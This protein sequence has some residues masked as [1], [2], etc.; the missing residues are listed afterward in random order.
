[1]G[2]L[3]AFLWLVHLFLLLGV[4]SSVGIVELNTGVC[5]SLLLLPFSLTSAN[6]E[7]FESETQASTGQ[8]SGRWFVKFYGKLCVRYVCRLN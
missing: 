6:A 3:R 5:P 2:A 4:A 1:M 8:T 7:N